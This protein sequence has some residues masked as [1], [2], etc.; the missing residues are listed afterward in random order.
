MWVVLVIVV[1]VVVVVVVMVVVVVVVVRR[2]HVQEK[3]K[4]STARLEQ[5]EKP[6][7][8]YPVRKVCVRLLRCI[9]TSWT[10]PLTG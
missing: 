9:L 5:R 2:S 6:L 1:V 3:S 4:E 10:Y 8:P 7:S